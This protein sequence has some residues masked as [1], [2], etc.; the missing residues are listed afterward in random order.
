MQRQLPAGGPTR[1]DVEM[2]NIFTHDK[3]KMNLLINI[4]SQNLVNIAAQ[5]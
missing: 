5:F 1:D 2:G 3:N 4:N